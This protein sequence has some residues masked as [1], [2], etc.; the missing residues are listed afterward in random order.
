MIFDPSPGS[1]WSGPKNAVARLIYVSNS[2]TKFVRI[3]SNGLEG[4]S[5]MDGQN[6]G[7]TDRGNLDIPFAFF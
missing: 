4:G 3:S 6:D 7:G 5:K 2:Y 1:H